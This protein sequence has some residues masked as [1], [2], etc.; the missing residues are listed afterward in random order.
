MKSRTNE[1]VE[2][3]EVSSNTTRHATVAQIIF[4]VINLKKTLKSSDISHA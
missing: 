4:E 3:I 2:Q 1:S